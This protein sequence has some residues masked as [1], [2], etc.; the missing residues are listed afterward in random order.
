MTASL[1]IDQAESLRQLAGRAKVRELSPERLQ[2]RE[3]LR[4]ISV[5]SGKGGVGKTSVV[6]NLAQALALSGQRVLIVDANPGM[7]EICLRLGIEAPYRLNHVLSGERTLEETVID[8]G[9]GIGIL[10]AGIDLQLYSSLSPAE[11]LSL[12]QGIT[13]LEDDYDFFL[14]D[15]GSGLS[16]NV[17]SFAS[18]ARE[19]MLVVTPEPTSIMDAYALV[20]T[21]NGRDPSFRFRLLVNMCRDAEEGASLFAKLSAI[22]G[23]FLEVELDYSG[24]ILKDELVAESAKMRGV[25]S[26]LFPDAKSSQGFRALAQK[27]AAYQPAVQAAAPLEAVPAAEQ[28][29]NHEL[30]S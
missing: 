17:T 15:T 14:I 25:H 11:R 21:L 30:S 22:T 8:A 2:L 20:K 18:F 16:A 24:C 10:P 6:V 3:E 9:S 13:R 1:A 19:I 5:T 29:R 23:R 4:V 28:W 26:R 27:I 7:G 12:L